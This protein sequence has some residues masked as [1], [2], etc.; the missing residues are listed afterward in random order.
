MLQMEDSTMALH[1][2]VPAA[3]RMNTTA[4]PAFFLN[5]LERATEFGLVEWTTV[6]DSGAYAKIV[7]TNLAGSLSVTFTKKTSEY[8]SPLTLEV[9]CK[10]EDLFGIR[11]TKIVLDPATFTDPINTLIWQ[12]S[13]EFFKKFYHIAVIAKLTK[14]I[15]EKN[16]S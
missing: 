7:A 16:V 15:D 2:L 5:V 11:H 14:K 4:N 10:D 12:K 8:R 9:N 3:V 1:L 13:A 6:S